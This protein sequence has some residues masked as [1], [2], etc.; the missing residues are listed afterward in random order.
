[1]LDICICIH[2]IRSENK[3]RGIIMDHSKLEDIN[4]KGLTDKKSARTT[5]NISESSIDSI[6]WLLEAL[7]LKPKELFDTIFSDSTITKHILEAEGLVSSKI[8]ETKKI[9]KSYV[10]SQR[11]LSWLNKKSKDK[12]LTRNQFVDS[13]VPVSKNIYK[14]LLEKVKEKEDRAWAIIGDIYE[15]GKEAEKKLID[16]LGEDDEIVEEFSW[17]IEALMTTG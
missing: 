12:N 2:Y 4:L 11:A 5:F 13:F 1:M 10:I 8:N 16:L 6:N 3:K 7:E 14:F 17:K 9:R 15:K